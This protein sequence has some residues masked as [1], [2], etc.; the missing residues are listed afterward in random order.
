MQR[1]ALMSGLCCH[2]PETQ[3]S[4]HPTFGAWCAFRAAVVFDSEAPA[5]GPP[6]PCPDLLSDAERAAARE[7]MANALKATN[8]DRI[9]EQCAVPTFRLLGPSPCRGRA[10]APEP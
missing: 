10:V 2:D 4:I 6:P 1:V 8:E 9:C 3:L 5:G 7:A